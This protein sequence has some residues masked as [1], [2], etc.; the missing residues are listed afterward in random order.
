MTALG[1]SLL[2]SHIN[3]PRPSET[4]IALSQLTTRRCLESG[5]IFLYH[6]ERFDRT[7][8]YVGKTF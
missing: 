2:G 8:E 5:A 1:P 3:L 6:A 4:V 7:G